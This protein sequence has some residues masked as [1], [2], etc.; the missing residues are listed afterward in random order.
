MAVR[1]ESALLSDKRVFLAFPALLRVIAWACRGFAANVTF[2]WRVNSASRLTHSRAPINAA[3]RCR[4][5]LELI[6]NTE[7]GVLH[8]KNN[9]VI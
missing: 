1:T 5:N 4:L 6:G 9:F 8:C 3:F 7:K 2:G